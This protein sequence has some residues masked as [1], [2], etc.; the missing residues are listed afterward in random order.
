MTYKNEDELQKD[1]V[2]YLLA[3]G[4]RY[5]HVASGSGKRKNGMAGMLDLIITGNGP[6]TLY[7]EIKNPNINITP[8]SLRPKQKEWIE[9]AI[10][11]RIPHIVTNKY[12]EFTKW[13]DGYIG[14]VNG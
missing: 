10:L 7:A 5:D 14:M 2:T 13:L 1:C 9:F 8:S 11:N 3:K 12:Q 4:F 6:L